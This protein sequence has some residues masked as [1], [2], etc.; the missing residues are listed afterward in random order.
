MFRKKDIKIE[1]EDKKSK[2]S[3][4]TDKYSTNK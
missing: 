3:L 4:L 1:N 2:W